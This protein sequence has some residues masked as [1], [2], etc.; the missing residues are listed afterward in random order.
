MI[1]LGKN[2]F[3][4]LL[5]FSL[6]FSLVLIGAGCASG[7]KQQSDTGKPT[8]IFADAGWDSMKFHNSVAQIIVEKG[9]GYPTDTMIG[10]TPITFD[11]LTRGNIHIYME[12]WTSNII[13]L[14]KPAIE[15]GDVIELG[16]N[17]DDNVQGLY[18]PT[19]LIKGDPERGIEPMAPDLKSI[20]DLPKYWELFKD[21]EEP[22]K[23]R[24]YGA[25]PGWEVDTILR[26]K[27]INYGLD[28]YYN[29]FSPGSDTALATSMVK[30]YEKGEPWLGYYWEPTW[31]MGLL[32]MTLLEDAPYSDELWNDGYKCAFPTVPCT[33]VVNKEVPEMA[34]DV[35]EF[36]KNYKTSSALTN[37]ALAYMQGN[38]ATP[39]DAALWFIK[40][41]QDL[42]TKWVPEEIAA[43]VLESI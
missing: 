35:V 10:S 9:Y 22:T 12:T 42:W 34:P 41:Y 27:I 20:K 36:L 26:Q 29:Y 6:I 25:I 30:A 23:G 17:F 24:I 13:E 33:V 11:G 40:E 32:D 37:E 16:V 2:A 14:Y 3:G 43:K 28:E 19:Y 18:V 21:P 8:L 5:I 1:S 7:D 39:M 31:V 38:E 15:S 4:R